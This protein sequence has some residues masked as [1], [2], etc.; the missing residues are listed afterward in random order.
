MQPEPISHIILLTG[1][2][3]APVLSQLLRGHNPALNIRPVLKA[4][5]LAPA[6]ADLGAGTRLISFCSPVIVPGSILAALPGPSYN[7]HPG[8]PERPGRYPSVFALYENAARF[9]VTVHEM[10][11]AVDSGPIV[12][13][14]HFEI[15]ANTDL[16]AL[17][18]LTLMHLLV[19][20]KLLARHLALDPAP[21]PHW[22]AAWSG[23]K[24][25]KAH[26]DAL[27]V[28]T[29]GMDAAE[30]NRRS[31]ACGGHLVRR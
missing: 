1:A 21:L 15:A 11:A 6:C 29:P 27:C 5:D 12:G 9:G 4:S 23:R 8:P 26:C 25:S 16:E 24:T 2:V 18:H 3:E 10:A 14:Q 28:I 30:V 22:P 13:A 7:F 19:M 31:R 17:E 20:F